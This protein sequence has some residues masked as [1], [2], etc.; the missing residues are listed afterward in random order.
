MYYRNAVEFHD[1][2]A[3]DCLQPGRSGDRIPVEARFSACSKNVPEA[4]PFSCMMGTEC[5][6]RGKIGR[7]VA[8]TTQPRLAPRLKKEWC[9]TSTPPSGLMAC[10][11]VKR[12]PFN[13]NFFMCAIAN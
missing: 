9:Y 13:F 5:F 3:C 12:L 11:R 7:G 8:L 6:S 4:H 10:S 1:L 2:Y